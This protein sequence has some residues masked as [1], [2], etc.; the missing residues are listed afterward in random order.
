M[1]MQE[2]KQVHLLNF[3]ATQ[4]TLSAQELYSQLCNFLLLCFKTIIANAYHQWV[5]LSTYADII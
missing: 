4:C 5:G 3:I 2:N 1:C